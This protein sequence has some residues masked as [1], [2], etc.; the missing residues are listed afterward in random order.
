MLKRAESISQLME[1][2]VNHNSVQ[3]EVSH[4]DN[5]L[6]EFNNLCQRNKVL[7]QD[8]HYNTKKN[9]LFYKPIS[10]YLVSR[11]EHWRGCKILTSVSKLRNHLH[12]MLITLLKIVIKI[13]ERKVP[14]RGSQNC[15]IES[16]S[17]FRASL[18]SHSASLESQQKIAK[19]KA[20][21]E[22]YE[23]FIGSEETTTTSN[24]KP[25]TLSSVIVTSSLHAHTLNNSP[26]FA[27]QFNL[28]AP[29][30]IDPIML[31]THPIPATK[32][33]EVSI[34][35]SNISSTVLSLLKMQSAPEVTIDISN[36]NPLDV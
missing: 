31:T 14:R 16:R 11:P 12:Q 10:K 5:E 4:L 21:M 7:L 9:H 15:S 19:S 33:D 18:E 1:S 13:S 17:R 24:A 35:S 2:D 28:A 34:K 25:V 29:T 6:E 22:I 8:G 32:S 20:K 30:F 3:N 27:S 26:T 36:G 23:K